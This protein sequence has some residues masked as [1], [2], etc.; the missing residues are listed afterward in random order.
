MRC[1]ITRGTNRED[2]P[3]IPPGVSKGKLPW[4]LFPEGQRFFRQQGRRAMPV[5]VNADEDDLKEELVQLRATD[6]D[7]PTCSANNPMESALRDRDE[8]SCHY[9]GA[10]FQVRISDE[11]RLKLKEL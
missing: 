8:I 11:G 6:F 1:D 3:R 9:C 4:H 2:Y 5:D 7:C 10:Q